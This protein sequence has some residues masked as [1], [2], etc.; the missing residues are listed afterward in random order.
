MEKPF[1]L[2]RASAARAVAAALDAG[3]VLAVAYPRRFHPGVRELKARIDNG[4]LGTICHCQGEQNAPAGL[5]MN[6]ASWRALASEAPAGGMTAGAPG[7]GGY[8]VTHHLGQLDGRAQ[9]PGGHDPPGDPAGEAALATL[10][11]QPGQVSFDVAVHDISGRQRLGAVH[12]HVEGAVGAVAEAALGTV[13]L[14]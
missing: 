11:E 3:I 13:E 7:G 4:R 5:F 8:G 1:T 12:A 10:G 14:W 2:D 6:P 9:G